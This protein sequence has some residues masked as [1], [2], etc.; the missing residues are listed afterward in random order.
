MVS[1]KT[2]LCIMLL[3]N[4]FIRFHSVSC[5]NTELYLCVLIGV[6]WS[7]WQ[8]SQGQFI[9]DLGC[10]ASPLSFS[11]TVVIEPCICKLFDLFFH[12]SH[13]DGNFVWSCRSLQSNWNPALKEL[14]LFWCSDALNESLTPRPNQMRCGKFPMTSS[15]SVHTECETA[16]WCDPVTTNQN[17]RVPTCFPLPAWQMSRKYFLWWFS[18][19]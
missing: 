16:A 15:F 4:C 14:T 11:M 19:L 17:I 3:G 1:E 6:M 9:K 10:V 12:F 8:G 5:F 13:L 7:S 18:L 2:A